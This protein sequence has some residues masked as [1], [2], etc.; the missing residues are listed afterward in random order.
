MESPDT[1]PSY[2]SDTASEERYVKN[3]SEKKSIYIISFLLRGI[4]SNSSLDHHHNLSTPKS[5]PSSKLPGRPQNQVNYF[6]SVLNYSFKS[7]NYLQTTDQCL[8]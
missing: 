3:T 7:N 1:M 6:D 5:K 2:D 4:M 8:C